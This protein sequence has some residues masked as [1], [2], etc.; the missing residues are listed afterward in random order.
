MNT[1]AK[2]PRTGNIPPNSDLSTI[3]QIELAYSYVAKQ[4]ALDVIFS[5]NSR[6]SDAVI[7]KE[8]QN[9]PSTFSAPTRR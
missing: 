8:G 5:D 4:P 2:T 1:I 7:I 6:L 9:A 3:L